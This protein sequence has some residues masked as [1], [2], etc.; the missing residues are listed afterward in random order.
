MYEPGKETPCDYGSRHPPECAKFNEQRNQIEEWCI[1]TRTDIY[2]NRVLE[3]ILPQAITLDILK[4]ASSKDK[5]LQLLISYIKTQNKSDCKK[6]LAAYYGI[7]DELT[8]VDGVVLR[9]SQIVIPESLQTDI[10][11]LADKGHQYTEKTQLRHPLHQ[12][13]N[14]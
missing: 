3:E 4:R 2:L 11:R 7:F 13:A 14:Q 6:H 1:E 9:G 10:I 8:E 5:T 12:I